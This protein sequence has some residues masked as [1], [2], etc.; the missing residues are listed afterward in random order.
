[1]W[2]II[3]RTLHFRDDGKGRRSDEAEDIVLQSQKQKNALL[4]YLA[5]SKQE[6][7]GNANDN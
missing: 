6:I 5:S 3:V 7:L 1:M 4:C 2:S